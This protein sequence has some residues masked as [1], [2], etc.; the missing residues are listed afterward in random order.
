MA[1]TYRSPGVY[2]EEIFLQPQVPLPTGIPAFVGRADAIAALVKLPDT[3]DLP[4]FVSY[5]SNQQRLVCGG[6]LGAQQ[7]LDLLELSNDRAFQQAVEALYISAQPVVKLRRWQ[8]FTDQLTGRPNGY[9]APVVQGFFANGGIHCYVLRLS[10][11]ELSPVALLSALQVLDAIDDLDL[12]A[13]PEVMG[14]L[15]TLNESLA[16]FDTLDATAVVEAMRLRSD[17]QA[18]LQAQKAVLTHCAQNGNRFAL[19]DALPTTALAVVQQQRRQLAIDQLEAINGALYYPWLK[20]AANQIVPP[21]GHIAGVIA[22]SD[23][24]RGVFKAPA[25]EL[26]SDTLD[27]VVL[28]LKRQDNPIPVVIDNRIQDQLNPEGINC[29]RAFPGR[30]I[31][32]WGARTLSRDPIWLYINVRRVVLT[33]GRWIDRNLRWA[34]FEPNSPRLWMRIQREL[35]TYLERLWQQGALQGAAPNQAFFVK[36]DAETNPTES[37][38][39]GNVVTEIGLAIAAPAEFVIVRIVHR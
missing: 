7:R 10:A 22:R 18:I 36:C 25:N 12:V 39:L 37:R 5:D 21:C 24:D 23:R 38:E 33:L 17:I 35:T 8:E 2:R 14:N 3:V 1:T 4:S 27:L 26:I 16:A 19:L 34:T 6:S 32:V 9:L 30:G 31:R 20:N 29:L 28:P 11:A 13:L 15:P